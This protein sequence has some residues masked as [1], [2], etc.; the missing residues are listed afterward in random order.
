[1]PVMAYGEGGPRLSPPDSPGPV[2]W[3]HAFGSWG[4][5]DGD[6]NA[7][8]MD[9]STGGFLAGI[10]GGIA[11]DIR[12]GFLTG[13]SHS[14]FDVDGRSSSGS[15]DNYHLG[16]Y[17]GARWNALRLTGGLAYTWH[18]ISTGRSV[19][20]PGFSDSLTGDY[21]AGTFQAFGEAGYKIGI[22]AASFEPFANLAYVN[23]HTDGF[24]EKG[25]AAA[26]HVRGE[27]TE[28]TF[29]TL[30]IHL[31][32]AF[33]I[34]GMK[35]KARGTFGWRHAFGDI[36]PLSTQAFAGGDAFTVAGVPIAKDAAVIEAG[37]DFAV[38]DNATFGIS[39]SGQFGSGARDN[40]AK[41]DLRVRF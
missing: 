24:T 16:L 15:S 11:S 4:S 7:A 8:A 37:L 33:D 31:A 41:A 3:G 2:A 30:G 36:T 21:S 13:Y 6:G 18:D 34:G 38:S 19:A 40:G 26:L 28:T 12:L 14:T 27:T 1:M 32:S 10:D 20:F 17:A 23:L 35:A 5:F 9:T 29:T 25:G 39:Y 22:G